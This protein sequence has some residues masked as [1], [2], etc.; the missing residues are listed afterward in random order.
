MKKR[1]PTRV[2]SAFLAVVMVFLMI[3]IS[4]I[5]VYADD[6]QTPSIDSVEKLRLNVVNG[7]TNKA[8]ANYID[9][10]FKPKTDLEDQQKATTQLA[11]T[12]S[13]KAFNITSKGLKLI[14]LIPQLKGAEVI[15]DILDNSAGIAGEF[16]ESDSSSNLV[17]IEKQLNGISKQISILNKNNKQGFID[18]ADYLVNYIDYEK[19]SEKLRNF[20]YADSGIKPFDEYGDYYSWKYDLY[21]NLSALLEA[22]KSISNGETPQQPLSFYYDNL[23]KVVEKSDVLYSYL[24]SD[25]AFE[26]L[27]ITLPEILY[28]YYLLG[29]NNSAYDLDN[30]KGCIENCIEY[31][32]DWYS[33]YTLSQ[34]ALTLCHTYQLE[35]LIKTYGAD[36]LSSQTYYRSENFDDI[37]VSYEGYIC[38]FLSN[39][40]KNIDIIKCEM[41]KYYA[42]IMCLDE[43]FIYEVNDDW[44]FEVQYQEILSEDSHSAIKYSCGLGDCY[45]RTNNKVSLGNT[46]YLNMMPE[47]FGEIFDFSLFDF[48]IESAD[49]S[50]ATVNKAG[51]VNVLGEKGNFKVI[52]TYNDEKVYEMDFLVEANPFL[53]GMGTEKVPYLLS[54]NWKDIETLADISYYSVPD[55]YFKL[56]SDID[57]KG[58]SFGGIPSF[59]GTLDGN[60]YSI[61]NFNMDGLSYYRGFIGTIEPSGVIKNLTIGCDDSKTSIGS[62]ESSYNET[63]FGTICGYNQGVIENCHVINVE[64]HPRIFWA[65][66]ATVDCYAGGIVGFNSGIITNCV[67]ESSYINAEARGRNDKHNNARASAGGIVGQ[68]YLKS[69]ISNCIV[70]NS[71]IRAYSFA[72]GGSVENADADSWVGGIYGSSWV[73]YDE[74]NNDISPQ[75][76]NNILYNTKLLPEGDQKDDGKFTPHW[77]TSG[78]TEVTS[79]ITHG[80]SSD[81]EY[82]PD[83]NVN[84]TRYENKLTYVHGE[85]H[86]LQDKY[87][88]GTFI[89]TIACELQNYR[90]DTSKIGVSEVTILESVANTNMYK[91]STVDITVV[92]KQAKKLIIYSPP[93]KTIYQIGTTVL[94]TDGLIL[95]ITYDNGTA[96]TL[97]RDTDET[98]KYTVKHFDF[99]EV[100]KSTVTFE[101]EGLTATMDVDVVC[102]HDNTIPVGATN[103]T[104]NDVGYTSGTYCNDCEIYISGH[105][106]IPVLSSHPYGEWSYF[107]ETQHVRTCACG[108]FEYADHAWNDGVVTTEATHLANGEKTY[109]CTECSATKTEEIPPI[110]GHT[111]GKWTKHNDAQHVRSCECGETEYAD[112]NWDD[113][114]I[115]TPATYEKEGERT[116]TCLDCEATYTVPIPIPVSIHLFV[117]DDA[118]AVPGGTMRVNVRLENNPGIA[119][120]RLK[121]SYDSSVLDLEQVNYNTEIGGTATQPTIYDGYVTLL[122]Y[123]D[124]ENV[125]GDWIFATLTFTVKDTA[126]VGSVSDIVLTYDAEEVCDIEENNIVFSIDNGSATVLDHVPGDIN[127]DDGLTSKDLLRL[128]RYFAGW[129]VEVNENALDINGDGNVNSKDL[130]RLARYLAGWD[131]EIY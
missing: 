82:L 123:N 35:S 103:A 80:G 98:S 50:I 125:E 124:S 44:I 33:T 36:K 107:S 16:A 119:M 117:V 12:A 4:T 81:F 45:I 29:T 58:N 26:D 54:E 118:S 19:Y 25:G 71:T 64:L 9:I 99:S 61:K 96:K 23:Y 62:S 52:M 37:N 11:L 21:F 60:G 46:L 22:E 69:S 74:N 88:A 131:V 65:G 92:E 6:D 127:G 3:P 84:S 73:G 7:V 8:L 128:A 14:S 75:Y 78:Y 40:M 31:S 68:S 17:E 108:E 122:W 49:P 66:S 85:S 111:F 70:S 48:Q 95:V 1:I 10:Q 94:E 101:Y 28:R 120:M 105:E 2:L 67:L 90:I 97:S 129:D 79:P 13:T 27:K 55:M 87:V 121:I 20:F 41:A 130:L 91:K 51:I 57:G 83:I 39:P 86:F 56:T 110:E 104:C 109:T 77:I 116:Y 89:E 18:L 38:P 59:S 126:P 113:G 15:A 42:R 30:F 106:E 93:I 24:V 5:L 102:Y 43:S 76:S 34:M 72:N 112:H 47:V 32:E 114:T 100:G 63:F 115:T 53:G